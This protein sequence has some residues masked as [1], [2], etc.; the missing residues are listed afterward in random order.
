[1]EELYYLEFPKGGKQRKYDVLFE[2]SI[3]HKEYKKKWLYN[4]Y[5]NNDE[6]KN[7]RLESSRRWKENNKD[8]IKEYTVEKW[9]RDK[10][11]RRLKQLLD[12]EKEGK[13]KLK[14]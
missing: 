8:K 10:E 12:N 4:N 13:I 7:K 6:F 2:G 3:M 11:K 14:K 5:H 1:M 9:L